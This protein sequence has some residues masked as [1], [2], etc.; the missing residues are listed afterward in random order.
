MELF[1][2]NNICLLSLLPYDEKV[3]IGCSGLD[4][5]TRLQIYYNRPGLHVAFFS[6]Y[7]SGVYVLA[8]PWGGDVSLNEDCR[9]CQYF[10]RGNAS[11]L[12]NWV[13]NFPPQEIDG[14]RE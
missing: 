10:C 14:L 9:F 13:P 4:C 11:M 7:T 5:K 12:L 8:R 2:I 6:F 1:T 3:A